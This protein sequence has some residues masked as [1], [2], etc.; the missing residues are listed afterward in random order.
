MSLP[1]DATAAPELPFEDGSPLDRVTGDWPEQIGPYRIQGRISRGGMGDVLAGYD[2]RLERSVALKRVRPEVGRDRERAERF[3]REAR[4]HARQSHPG[5]VRVYEVREFDGCDYIVSELVHGESLDTLVFGRARAQRPSLAEGV[6]ICRAIVDAVEHLHANEV[7]H[8]DLKVE[9]ILIATD[10]TVKLTDF[11]VSHPLYGPT[12]GAG[13]GAGEG[14]S[15]GPLSAAPFRTSAGRLTGTL[16]CM[17]PEQSRGEPTD[18]RSD[19]FSLGVCFYEIFAGV[20]PFASDDPA[21]TLRSIQEL[22]PPP[23]AELRP[24]I[25]PALSGLCAQLLEKRPADRPTAPAVQHALARIEAELGVLASASGTAAGAIEAVPR[26]LAVAVIRARFES[27][28]LLRGG[29]AERMGV[30]RRIQH[31]V[32]RTIET[33]GGS[34]LLAAGNQLAVCVGHPVSHDNNCQRAARLLLDAQAAVQ[35][36][37]EGVPVKLALGLA[38][39]VATVVKGD[40]PLRVHGQLVDDAIG[41][42]LAADAGELLVSPSA[43]AVLVRELELQPRARLHAL[44]SG[45]EVPVS[46]VVG[47]RRGRLT[48][49]PRVPMVG[50]DHHRPRLDAAWRAV[51]GGEGRALLVTGEAGVGK[52]RFLADWLER[53][54]PGARQWTLFGTE[55]GL[56]AP[57][58]PLGRLLGER[59]G[60]SAE[61]EP[62]AARVALERG[63]SQHGI[64]DAAALQAARVLFGLGT[65]GDG[66]LG[67][68]REELIERLAELVLALVGRA[69]AVLAVEDLH[70]VDHSSLAVLERLVERGA[71]GPLLV[72]MT[73]RPGIH[74]RWPVAA[75][76]PSLELGRLD[77]AAST[78]LVEGFAGGLPPRVVHT[79]VQQSAGIPLLLEE[80]SRALASGSL[81]GAVEQLVERVPTSLR[82]SLQR[83]L[84][85]L[86]TARRTLECV[87]VL[88][89]DAPAELLPVVT[90]LGAE[91][92]ERH[93]DEARS[94]GLLAADGSLAFRHARIKDA[95]YESM[96]GG[97]REALHGRV[98]ELL[99]GRFAELVAKRPEAYAHHYEIAGATERAVEVCEAAATK[100]HQRWAYVEASR[101]LH[102][103]LGSLARWPDADE[104]RRRERRLLSGLYPVELANHGWS[105]PRVQELVARGRALEEQL[106]EGRDLGGLYVQWVGSLVSQSIEGVD[107]ALAKIAGLD[108]SP[109]A[110]FM[111]DFTRGVTSFHRGE[112]GTAGRCLRAA[113]EALVGTLQV[114]LPAER[115]VDLSMISKWS[116]DVPT[117]PSLYLAILEGCRGRF[118][119]SDRYQEEAEHIAARFGSLY[120]ESF[121]LGCRTVLA[122]VRRD[123][124][125]FAAK[126]PRLEEICAGDAPWFGYARALLGMA[127]SRLR[128]EAGEQGPQV[129]A[130]FVNAVRIL[131]GMGFKV[132][133]ELHRAACAD[134]CREAGE[135]DDAQTHVDEGLVLA[136]HELSRTYAMYVHLAAARLCRAR[137]DG[138]GMRRHVEAAREA[139]RR[140]S[141]GDE[142]AAWMRYC[143]AATE[144]PSI[145]PFVPGR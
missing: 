20:S 130:D 84:E 83:R 45:R 145:G 64:D 94:E 138:A 27:E 3:L 76:M 80:L 98:V 26:Q 43:H 6:R 127:K 100:A 129:V 30:L 1:N 88:G 144:D 33:M 18:E 51:Q 137:A 60:V 120:A 82:D 32:T 104:R 19:M 74:E 39:G 106:G 34:V 134:A 89:R 116:E 2:T 117:G 9:N 12:E 24:G 114:D 29:E 136:E 112:L 102:A 7:V 71:R 59:L 122:W 17:S 16:R 37:A 69:P 75:S 141:E 128:A 61:L 73:S 126:L 23:L 38:Y 96:P 78:A 70:W 31:W 14:A 48:A 125:C 21:A 121:A 53:V 99:E 62:E 101:H 5:I 92:V 143:V 140:V 133:T 22:T 77:P 87:A 55:E 44:A 115:L 63:L 142:T 68:G 86:G 65:R 36:F 4:L 52:T 58:A 105:D 35:A 28:E 93:L 67:P 42:A 41:L 81:D 66:G 25:P 110:R 56:Y 8:R 103:A 10:G 131:Q 50:R 72:V 109:E 47:P 111:Q 91:T 13:E 46:R 118:E 108:P 124:R 123:S 132:S 15:D 97:Q 90:G 113:R 57:F 49:T 107:D 119:R 11:G 95:V 79:I 40:G 139:L 54:E 135:L 85:G